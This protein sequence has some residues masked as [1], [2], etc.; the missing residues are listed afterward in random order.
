MEFEPIQT[1][2]A[3]DEIIKEKVAEAT[4]PFKDYEDLKLQNKSLNDQLVDQGRLQETISTLTKERDEFKK[5]ALKSRISQEF[6]LPK[7]LA[8][9]LKGENEEEL[10]ADAEALSELYNSIKPNAPRK[11]NE[12]KELESNEDAAYKKLLKDLNFNL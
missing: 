4:S 3:L 6:G 1:Q 2:E 9:R 10:K 8:E 5:Q 11:D 12:P 7:Q